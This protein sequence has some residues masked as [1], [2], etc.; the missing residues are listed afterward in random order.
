[1]CVRRGELWRGGGG[2]GV[3]VEVREGAVKQRDSCILSC[4]KKLLHIVYLKTAEH[5][6][7]IRKHVI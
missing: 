6:S 2:T 3:A 1:M 7:T 4:K 5:F